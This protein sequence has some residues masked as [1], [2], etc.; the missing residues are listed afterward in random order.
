MLPAPALH[1]R[2]VFGWTGPESGKAARG[3][4]WGRHG[5]MAYGPATGCSHSPGGGK[6]HRFPHAATKVPRQR[7]GGPRVP[8]IERGVVT[9]RLRVTYL[10]PVHAPVC[11]TFVRRVHSETFEGGIGAPRFFAS[12]WVVCIRIDRVMSARDAGAR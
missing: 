6:P 5:G 3:A 9:S 10:P 12:G 11:L 8:R 4:G 2:P 7:Y 1:I